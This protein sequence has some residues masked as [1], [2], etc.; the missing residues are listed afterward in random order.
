[1]MLNREPQRS[2]THTE[3]NPLLAS[4]GGPDVVHV[5]A[6]CIAS[7]PNSAT[8]RTKLPTLDYY[9]ERAL[10]MAR[11]QDVV[12]VNHP[13]DQDY[14]DFL[15]RM[16]IGPAEENIIVVADGHGDSAHDL[17]TR[18]LEHA[19]A[20]KR[21]AARVRG[22]QRIVLHPLYASHRMFD[23]AT[24][25]SRELGRELD[26]VGGDPNVVHNASLKH[27]GRAGAIELGIPVAPG[28]VIE[29][30]SS[31]GSFTNLA[32]L[33]QA[34][35]RRAKLTGRAIIRGA[36][37]SSG[38]ATFLAEKDPASID[39]VIR[40]IAARC[41][42]HIYLVEVFFEN[43]VSPNIQVF[44]DAAGADIA[45][46]SATDQILNSD[47]KHT[48]NAHPS[49]ALALP[50]MFDAIRKLAD[51]LRREGFT[52]TVGFDCVEYSDPASGDRKWFLAEINPRINA[53]AYPTALMH[54]L[55]KNHKG[56]AYI[57]AFHA[58]TVKTKACSFAELQERYGHLFFDP[59]SCRG[60]F[61]YNTG[62]LPG[63]TFDAAFLG[64]S[65]E[66]VGR[67]AGDFMALQANG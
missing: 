29:L 62:C 61:P 25:L 42:N 14:L 18:L 5:L 59:A 49:E 43:I 32:D 58:T 35:E 19:T 21:I 1:V 12:C 30:A 4:M 57:K 34:I 24:V 10:L 53:A 51:G 36:S 41:D 28:E 65:R 66:E 33:R 16:D 45:S 47:L 52:G 9:P 54:R 48:G 64:S 2:G 39:V 26:V 56:S 15:K 11:H 63:G 22:F 50:H 20:I 46:P 23:L 13:V 27:R 38:S 37:G 40:A 3:L 6:H 31:N 8:L 7:I 60:L 67:M 55:N 17:P 44:I